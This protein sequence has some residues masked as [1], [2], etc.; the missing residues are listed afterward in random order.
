MNITTASERFL[1]SLAVP[2]VLLVIGG[3]GKHLV[4]SEF[5]WSNFYL[6]QDFALSGISLGLLNFLEMLDAK[7]IKEVGGAV[8]WTVGYLTITIGIYM[9]VLIL[10][11]NIE[12][13]QSNR[14]GKPT[15]ERKQMGAG[16]GMGFLANFFGLI[17]SFL[18]AWL[19]LKGWL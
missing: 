19:K 2:F 17:P 18:F 7:E 14:E 9:L 13:R 16:I 4:A 5:R 3:L 12:K 15:A 1:L 8:L 10:H 6:G 11:Q